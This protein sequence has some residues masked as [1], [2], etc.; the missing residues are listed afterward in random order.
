[1][2]M[3]STAFSA[4][5]M[6]PYLAWGIF[7]LRLRYR[8][9]EEL[10]FRTESI[11]LAVVVT[12]TVAELYLL[13]SV[14][15]ENMIL[16]LFTALGLA[17]SA[18]ALYGPMLVS[19]ASQIFVDALMAHPAQK[20]DIANFAPVEALERIGEHEGA[21]NECLVLI[22][23]FPK[24][25]TAPLR[26]AEN[27]IHLERFEEAATWFE[28]GLAGIREAD[29]ALRIV[30]RLSEIYAKRLDRRED[31]IRVLE[32]YIETYPESE[33]VEVIRMRLSKLGEIPGPAGAPIASQDSAPRE[34]SLD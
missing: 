20:L 4:L 17:V 11:T 25:P 31:A 14:M 8:Y 24:D 7:T 16:Y 6:L 29:R 28:R 33:R 13:K 18:A 10:S 2:L 9:H 30:N 15:Q 19:V 23:I 12:L 27:L 22:R 34:I 3:F 5:L 32:A 1:M 26:A 21:F